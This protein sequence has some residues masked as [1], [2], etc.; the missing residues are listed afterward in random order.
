MSIILTTWQSR[1]Y[2]IKWKGYPHEDNTWEPEKNLSCPLLI[3][4][5]HERQEEFLNN[6]DSAKET[7]S[8]QKRPKVSPPCAVQVLSEGIPGNIA[9]PQGIAKFFKNS[10][11]AKVIPKIEEV[12]WLILFIGNGI[13]NIRCIRSRS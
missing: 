10:Q 11:I 4:R 6:S 13:R 2:L 1:Y 9:K 7:K 3:K 12:T 5:F 8:S